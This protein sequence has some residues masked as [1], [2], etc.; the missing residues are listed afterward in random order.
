M[1]GRFP[2]IGLQASLFGRFRQEL[3]GLVYAERRHLV[4]GEFSP[5]SV[6]VYGQ[7]ERGRWSFRFFRTV[8]FKNLEISDWALLCYRGKYFRIEMSLV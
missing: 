4:P 8:A 1:V 5:P 6:V 7:K 2:S 3:A